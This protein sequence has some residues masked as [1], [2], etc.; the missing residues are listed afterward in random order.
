MRFSHLTNPLA[1]TLALF[2]V[3]A[4]E[5]PPTAPDSEASPTFARAERSQPSVQVLDRIAAFVDGVNARFA[6]SG[7]TTRLDY[8]WLFK[9][10]LG[11][12]PYQSL[13]TGPRWTTS[14]PMYVLDV[15]DFGP[16]G[17]NDA[18]VEGVL[19]SA[20]DTWNAV[21]E[22]QLTAFRGPNP[23]GN[24][25]V[26]DGMKLEDG[27]CVEPALD[28]DS[29]NVVDGEVVS[30][31]ANIVVGGFLPVEYFADCLGSEDILAVTW[32]FYGPDTN[33]DQYADIV[34]VEQYFN[35]GFTWVTS[36][37]QYLDFSDDATIDLETIALHEDG[38]AHGLGHF[39]GP[40]P[41]QSL[42][43]KGNGDV[44]SPEAVMNAFYLGGED[45]SLY[46]IDEGALL[47]MYARGQ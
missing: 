47:T 21:P 5:R 42:R 14:T 24:V 9:V 37:S 15:A 3:S 38:H 4:C 40:L 33:G 2:A 34:Y 7:Q 36:G 41:R 28:E 26:A 30:I 16:S 6:A 19:M 13:R 20:Y 32:T 23:T 18:V 35:P 43:L 1:L 31:S 45:R 17:L 39:G 10:G 25:D 44:F 12:D 22:S 8:P 46:P 29:E 11:T 27:K